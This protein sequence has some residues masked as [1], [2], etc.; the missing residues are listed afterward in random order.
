M[1]G[2]G[3]RGGRSVLCVGLRGA[4]CAVCARCPPGSRIG[5][6]GRQSAWRGAGPAGGGDIP[7]K[8]CERW[9]RTPTPPPPAVMSV[10]A[11][12]VPPAQPW[13]RCGRQGVRRTR[14]GL[15]PTT[16]PRPPG[17][18]VTQLR[19]PHRRVRDTRRVQARACA[20]PASACA[21]A[22]PARPCRCAPT[23]HCGPG[24]S[25]TRG[26]RSGAERS[27]VPLLHIAP[28]APSPSG[29]NLP[30]QP[31]LLSPSRSEADGADA[32]GCGPL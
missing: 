6:E 25:P 11:V 30:L 7:A 12:V 24:G 29:P 17:H 10:R 19:A 4:L 5:L 18:A 9:G 23:R 26:G 21:A 2:V 14:Q 13:G 1:W 22:R 28:C 20:P 31:P 16:P 8:Q 15:H 3:Q 27:G 32:A